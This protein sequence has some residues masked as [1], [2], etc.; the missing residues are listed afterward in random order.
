MLAVRVTISKFVDEIQPG[1]VECLLVDV[2]GQAWKFRVKVP[3]VSTESL[4]SDSQYP[5]PGLIPCSV[6]RR[7]A[8]R[9]G[10]QIV[11][12]DTSTP[13]LIESTDGVAVFDVFEEQLEET[14][15]KR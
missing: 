2:S 6:L 15:A 13:Y 14:V 4:W 1:W 5:K 12:I 8:D 10:R 11:T 3:V 7:N 9:A